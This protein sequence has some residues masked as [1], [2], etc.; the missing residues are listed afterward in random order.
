MRPKM[1]P[2]KLTTIPPMSRL[3]P[4]MPPRKLTVLRLG[5]LRL[6]PPAPV[7]WAIRGAESAK[8][9]KAIRARRTEPVRVIESFPP[10]GIVRLPRD[11]DLLAG[12]GTWTSVFEEKPNVRYKRSTCR[13]S[14][15]GSRKQD[16]RDLVANL[17]RDRQ[18]EDL[19]DRLLDGIVARPKRQ[20]AVLPY[21][22]AGLGSAMLG[23]PNAAWVHDP[24]LSQ[25]HREGQMRMPRE[26]H[27]G[28][29]SL[30][31][32]R[33]P[34]GL[35]GAVFEQRLGRGGMAKKESMPVDGARRGAWQA[36]QERPLIRVEEGVRVLL[37]GARNLPEGVRGLRV[38]SVAECR[39][40]VPLNHQCGMQANEFQHFAWIRAV[41]HQ[42]S[43]YP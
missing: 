22:I 41:V 21:G 20:V 35:G 4:L 8:A 23:L 28:L 6:A 29:Q 1:K 10:K 37:H 11:I 7:S 19:L 16:R 30:D 42:V 36:A 9:K 39:I 32:R 12:A 24:Q 3:L 5:S 17:Q 25:V 40:V 15:R 13:N 26:D 43:E 31:L 27:I 34:R 2:R 14:M 38:R 33:P 18:G